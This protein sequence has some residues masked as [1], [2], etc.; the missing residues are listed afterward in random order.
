MG[1]GG[2]EASESVQK[3]DNVIVIANALPVQTRPA[4]DCNRLQQT[5]TDCNTPQHTATGPQ[6]AVQQTATDC[7]TLQ[8]TATGPRTAV[9]EELARMAANIAALQAQMQRLAAASTS[10]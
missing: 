1:A 2:V 9:Q 7:N 3:S 6:T 8:Q 4:T 5:A 10:I